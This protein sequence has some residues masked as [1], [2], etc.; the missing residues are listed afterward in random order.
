MA[1]KK[2]SVETPKTTSYKA[3]VRF[4]QDLYIELEAVKYGDDISEIKAK[5]T[6]GNTTE[7]Y[8]ATKGAPG[9]TLNEETI[10]LTVGE[11]YQ[12]IATVNPPGTPLVWESSAPNSKATV[13]QDGLVHAKGPG[14]C[15]ITATM[16][17]QGQT[18]TGH[19]L[20]EITE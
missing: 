10:N 11:D 3:G 5:V 7:I 20:V 12:L 19:C 8:E 4:S 16:T 14:R 18:Y 15:G 1:R 13:T 6:N 9:V 2:R 17:Y